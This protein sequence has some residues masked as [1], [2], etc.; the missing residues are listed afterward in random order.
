[1]VVGGSVVGVV[2]GDVGGVLVTCAVD[3]V[4][5]RRLEHRAGSCLCQPINQRSVVS[6]I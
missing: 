3:A 5:A 6:Y 2:G 1:M 4:H